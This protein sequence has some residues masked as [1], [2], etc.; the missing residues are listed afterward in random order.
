MGGL[1]SF[2]QKVFLVCTGVPKKRFRGGDVQRGA[3]FHSILIKPDDDDDDFS[4]N[5]HSDAVT[6]VSVFGRIHAITRRKYANTEIQ[7]RSIG[8]A[9]APRRF[10]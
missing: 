8:H 7:R 4:S 10:L 5:D 6:A 9:D 3:L 2:L 1:D